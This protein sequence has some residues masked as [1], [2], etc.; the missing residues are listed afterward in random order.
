MKK[1][2]QQSGAAQYRQGDVLLER[3]DRRPKDLK[4]Q[5]R[6][7]GRVIL[8]YGETTGHAHAFTEPAT[9]KFVDSGGGEYFEVRG[10][11]FRCNLPIV[12]QWRGQVLVDHPEFGLVEFAAADVEIR[13]GRATIA[14]EFALLRHDEHNTQGIPAGLYKGGG[15][16]RTVH[17]REYSPEELRRVAD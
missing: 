12:R 4:Q 9:K 3:I 15:A 11:D 13:D 8:A 17:Q 1:R 5:D 2:V 14:G 7:K 16:E 6:D 10:R